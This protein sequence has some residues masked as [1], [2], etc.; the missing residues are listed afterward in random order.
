MPHYKFSKHVL[1]IIC[2]YC[3]HKW[4]TISCPVKIACPKCKK[5][6]VLQAKL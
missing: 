3:E 5:E 6:D 2:G 4:T 1:T